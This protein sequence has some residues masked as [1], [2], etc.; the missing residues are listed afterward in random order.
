MSRRPPK[1]Q[2][3]H[4]DEERYGYTYGYTKVVGYTQES[5]EGQ[6]LEELAKTYGAHDTDWHSD[7]E[8]WAYFYTTETANDFL[9]DFTEHLAD[10][11][12]PPF[13]NWTIKKG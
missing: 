3:R 11:N 1:H 2:R 10:N 6:M 12:L 7:K 13:D 5:P 8:F 4:A 9:D